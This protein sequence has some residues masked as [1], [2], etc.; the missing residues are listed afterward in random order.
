[1]TTAVVMTVPYLP[2]E[3][4][5][6]ESAKAVGDQLPNHLF[7]LKFCRMSISEAYINTLRIFTYVTFVAKSVSL[8][9]QLFCRHFT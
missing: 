9:V 8:P 6:I 7:L 1:M 5:L 2:K 4:S 3:I